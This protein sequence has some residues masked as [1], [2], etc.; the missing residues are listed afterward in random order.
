MWEGRRV[1]GWGSFALMNSVE[2]IGKELAFN[3]RSYEQ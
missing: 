3:K 2:N 1:L